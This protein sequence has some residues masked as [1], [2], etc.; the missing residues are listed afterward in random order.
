M[1]SAA[2]AA[3]DELFPFFSALNASIR[4]LSSVSAEVWS[5]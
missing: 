3:R 5:R 1:A 4:V 2:P